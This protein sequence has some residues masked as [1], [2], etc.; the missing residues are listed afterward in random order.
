MSRAT[1]RRADDTPITIA[2]RRNAERDVDFAPVLRDPH[3]LIMVDALAAGD[4]RQD[5]FFFGEKIV[6]NDARNRAA[7]H[8]RGRVNED[9]LGSGVPGRH[10]PVQ[11]LTDDRIVP[12]TRRWPR[13]G[14][15][16]HGWRHAPKY[17]RGTLTEPRQAPFS[18]NIGVGYGRNGMMPAIRVLGNDFLSTNRRP[19]ASATAIGDLFKWKHRPVRAPQLPKRL[20][21]R[22]APGR[23]AAPRIRRPRR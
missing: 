20:P 19:W 12:T 4:L 17:R 8:Y 23:A 16:R 11:R 10:G 5:P 15:C 9:A 2:H 3:G 6:G 7:V 18:S 22:R 14:S 21:N 13:T 1:F